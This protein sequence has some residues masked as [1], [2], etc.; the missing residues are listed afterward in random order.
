MD[1]FFTY[2]VVSIIAAKDAVLVQWLGYGEIL[3]LTR[4]WIRLINRRK[5]KK[6]ERNDIRLSLS[7]SLSLSHACLRVLRNKGVEE[8]RKEGGGG[9]NTK[10]QSHRRHSFTNR[11]LR[12]PE[13]AR[14]RV[15]TTLW[16]V[17]Q[18]DKITVGRAC[19]GVVVVEAGI[20]QS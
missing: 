4:Q 9:A 20:D 2:A 7:L 3:C 6:K 12:A 1:L 5:P 18:V 16:S 19:A 15:P 8:G 13:H 17:L 10:K 11:W 14:L